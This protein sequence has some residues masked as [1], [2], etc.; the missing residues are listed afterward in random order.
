MVEEFE[1]KNFVPKRWYDSK[2]YAGYVLDVLEQM[3]IRLHYD[4]AREVIKVIEVIKVNNR[5]REEVPLSL[6][7]ERVLGLYQEQHK[8]RWYDNNL[9]ISRVFK[10]ASCLPDEDFQNIMQGISMSLGVTNE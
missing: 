10:T 3:P 5:E 6:G 2:P 4:V 9:P 1:Q 7:I 8:R